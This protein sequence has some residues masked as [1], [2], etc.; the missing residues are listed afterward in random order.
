MGGIPGQMEVFGAVVTTGIYCR[1]GC[2]ATPLPG[3]TTS[4]P[5]A[6][7]AESAGFRACLRC[8]PYRFPQPA[9]WEG[10]EL[11][12]RA[13]RMIQA[14]AL[15]NHGETEL[16][17]RLGLSARH[18]RRLFTDQVGA[19]PDELARSTRAHFA[20]RLLDDTD[21]PVSEI[22]FA[23]GYGSVRQLNRSFRQVFRA[24][25]SQLRARR[26]VRDRL[27]ADGGLPLRLAFRG[28]LD[29]AWLAGSLATAAIPGVEHVDGAVYRRTIMI[30]GDP[31][32]LELMPGEAGAAG[33][34]GAGGAGAGG[35]AG[36]AGAGGAAGAA[37]EWDSLRLVLHLPHWGGLIHIVRRARQIAALDDDLSEPAA[38]LGRDPVVGP[39]LRARPGVRV[40][41]TW[42]PFESGVLAIIGGR[43]GPRA[44]EIAGPLARRSGRAVPGLRE[45]GLT[46][47]FPAARDLAAAEIDGCGGLDP[48]TASQVRSFARSVLGGAV[49]LD[50]SAGLKD[51]VASVTGC[52]GAEE[53]AAQY[54]A[55]R[56]GERD[57]F[58]AAGHDGLAGGAA[59]WRPWRALAYAHLMA[60]GMRDGAP[61]TPN[62]H[63]KLGARCPVQG[64]AALAQTVRATH[65]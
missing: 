51:L 54:L 20:R 8:R 27:V 19:T 57:A 18:L 45:F 22:A 61:T 14:G 17:A 38:R 42:D 15:D 62:G 64:R 2:G 39:L 12:C 10:S 41:G 25:P 53:Q 21:I 32:V 37:G 26:R 46:H 65:S 1:P 7:A 3:N 35:A 33:G 24:T 50:R 34:A 13:V 49:R 5:T 29:W 55:W 4:Y 63:G 28:P 40:P 52:C 36:E 30:D 58:P 43:Y 48:V 56:M 60:A 9:G 23:A 59:G 11:V 47:T 44:P 31:G 6:A 16:A